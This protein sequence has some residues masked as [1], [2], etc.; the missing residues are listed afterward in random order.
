M[1]LREE[2]GELVHG[3]RLSDV[4]PMCTSLCGLEVMRR[5][6]WSCN[7]S[8]EAKFAKCSRY[9]FKIHVLSLLM[10]AADGSGAAGHLA[11]AGT[12]EH[13]LASA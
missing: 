12:L 10:A 6:S 9:V 5:D 11:R 2:L 7:H 8:A 4:G 3:P 1:Q 13:C